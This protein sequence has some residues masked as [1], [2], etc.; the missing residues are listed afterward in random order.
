M[1]PTTV[2]TA[3]TIGLAAL[4]TSAPVSFAVTMIY[5]ARRDDLR[6]RRERDIRARD[7]REVRPAVRLVATRRPDSYTAER[8]ATVP[9]LVGPAALMPSADR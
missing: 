2:L 8:P 3:T 5:R 6:T 9:G 1:E 7:A 4:V